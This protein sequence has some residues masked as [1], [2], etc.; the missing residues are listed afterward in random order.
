MTKTKIAAC[1]FFFTLALAMPALADDAPASAP[2]NMGGGM[3]MGGGRQGGT[4]MPPGGGDPEIRAALEACAAQ[5]GKDAN[6]RPDH[7]AIHACMQA[8]G[9]TPP[10]GG[11]GGG[12]HMGGRQGGATGSP[13][14][15]APPPQ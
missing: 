7:Q 15:G 12:H 10:Q 4:G 3:G 8:K 2:G 11:M 13:P 9:F 6:G 5:T 14:Q 1:S